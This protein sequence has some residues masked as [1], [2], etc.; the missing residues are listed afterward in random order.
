MDFGGADIE[1]TLLGADIGADWHYNKFWM[2]YQ[3]IRRTKEDATW[4]LNPRV[5]NEPRKNASLYRSHGECF[6]F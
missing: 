3:G 6:A 5:Y 1:S 2:L 4:S